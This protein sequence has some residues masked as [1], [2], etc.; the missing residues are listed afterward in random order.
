[1]QHHRNE[2]QQFVGLA[3]VRDG[4][5]HIAFRHYAQVAVI[6]V[7]RIDEERGRSR[8]SQRGSNLRADVATL[9]HTRYNNLA[10]TVEYQLHSLV[11]VGVEL[12]YQVQHSLRLISDALYGKFSH[13]RTL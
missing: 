9:A 5:H 13:A 11:E 3:G 1:M 12:R 8:R 4:Q 7:Q 6:D 10:L 2:A